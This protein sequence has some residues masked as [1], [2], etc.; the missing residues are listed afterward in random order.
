MSERPLGSRVE[1]ATPRHQTE[2]QIQHACRR[3]Q[4]GRQTEDHRKYENQHLHIRLDD[5]VMGNL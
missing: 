5:R 3:G 4:G 2:E 1:L